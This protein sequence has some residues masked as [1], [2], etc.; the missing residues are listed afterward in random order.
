MHLLLWFDNFIVISKM[1]FYESKGAWKLKQDRGYSTIF[2]I[3]D[4]CTFKE[5]CAVLIFQFWISVAEENLSPAEESEKVGIFSSYD[6]CSTLR[7][8][9]LLSLSNIVPFLYCREGLITPTLNFSFMVR[10]QLGISSL[11]SSSVRS[12]TS[13]VMKLL[14]MKVTTMATQIA[15]AW[16][17]RYH[18]K[19]YLCIIK[20]TC[21][22]SFNPCLCSAF[23]LLEVFWN[24]FYS[25][26]PTEMRSDELSVTAWDGRCKTRQPLAN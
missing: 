17:A 25:P 15:E 13:H 24:H 10:T 6:C 23:M 14:E 22:L 3:E 18:L 8:L 20:L 19:W 26:P 12:M 7:V 1:N 5:T 11:S 2:I 21:K 4:T 16:R 9:Y